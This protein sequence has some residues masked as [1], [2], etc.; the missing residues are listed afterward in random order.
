VINLQLRNSN[1]LDAFLEPSGV[2]LLIRS[3]DTGLDIKS[4]RT[5]IFVPTFRKCCTT[6]H[7]FT[8]QSVNREDGIICF[9]S[10]FLYT[11]LKKFKIYFK[12][13]SKTALTCTLFELAKASSNNALPDDG[14][15]T[16]KCRSC[17]NVNF[18]INFKIVFKTIRLCISWYIKTFIISRCTACMWKKNKIYIYIWIRSNEME[19]HFMFS[20]IQC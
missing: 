16:K 12:I 13:E 11:N 2:F 3:F 17:F 8:F 4:Q 19:N 1:I 9:L 7:A 20:G 5:Q 14:D 10:K 6:H 18:K 15:C